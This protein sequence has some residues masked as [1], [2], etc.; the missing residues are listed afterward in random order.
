LDGAAGTAE[1]GM[2]M[3]LYIL[4]L[5]IGVPMFVILLVLITEDGFSGLVE[6]V[7]KAIDMIREYRKGKRKRRK[8][9]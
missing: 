8:E 7:L 1:G 9:G 6:D 4:I 2:N 3:G 5:A